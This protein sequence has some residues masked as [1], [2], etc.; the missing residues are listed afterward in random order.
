MIKSNSTVK[1]RERK[2]PSKKFSSPDL[3][4]IFQVNNK[5]AFVRVKTPVQFYRHLAKK[6]MLLDIIIYF[7]SAYIIG[8]LST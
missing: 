1:K 6:M 8:Y 7:K 5:L 4:G 2:K 3:Y